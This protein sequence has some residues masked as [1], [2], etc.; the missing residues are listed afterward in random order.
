MNKITY[1]GKD[2]LIVLDQEL[3]EFKIQLLKCAETSFS[4]HDREIVPP[5]VNNKKIGQQR[6]NSHFWMLNNKQHG[7]VI[8]EKRKLL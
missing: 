5:T 6:P 4:G 3:V 7:N 1:K 8:S 2:L